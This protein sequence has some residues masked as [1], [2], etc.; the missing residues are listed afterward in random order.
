[1]AIIVTGQVNVSPIF[2]VAQSSQLIIGG[3]QRGMH[4]PVNQAMLSNLAAGAVASTSAQQSTELLTDYK[5]GFYLGTPPRAQMYGQI[6]GCLMAVFFSPLMFMLFMKGY[7]CVLDLSQA[8]T[9]AFS[10][11]AIQG[12]RA[13]AVAILDPTFPIPRASWV[14]GIIFSIIGIAITGLR[15]WANHNKREVLAGLLPNMLMV[16]M[17]MLIPA[18]QYGIAFIIGALIAKFWKWKQP[19]S[20]STFGIAVAAGAIAG[21]GLGGVINALLNLLK[22]GGPTYYGTRLGCPGGYC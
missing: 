6:L 17:G 16:C 20:F 3:I 12:Y 14:A 15:T 21:E 10:G 18:I 4:L 11:P 2:A 13:I 22:V 9:C 1:M 19:H 5:I 8:A 7:P